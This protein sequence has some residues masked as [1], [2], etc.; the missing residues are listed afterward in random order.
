MNLYIDCIGGVAGDMLLAALIDAGAPLTTINAELDKLGIPGLMA[1]VERV[2]RHSLD[3]CHVNVTWNNP[4]SNDCNQHDDRAGNSPHDDHAHDGHASDGHC[5]H[6]DDAHDGPNDRHG[7]RQYAEIRNMLH[8][9][10]LATRVRDR[11]LCAF[12]LLAAAESRMHGIESNDVHFHEV[13]SEDSIADVVGVSVAL[14]L[15]EVDDVVC[16]PLPLGRGFVKSAHGMLPLPAPA[17][18]EIL[19]GIPTEGVD[20]QME[21]VTPTGAALVASLSSS[22]GTFPSMRTAAVGY[23]A[24]RRDLAQRPNIVRVVLGKFSEDASNT[25]LRPISNEVVLLETN[26]DDCSPELV[27]DAVAAAMTA[28][29]LD[30]WTTPAF[31]KKGRPG[32]VLSALARRGDVAGVADAML[33]ETSALGIRMC[34]YQRIEL[35]RS[36]VVVLVDNEPVSVKLG[37][38]DNEVVNVAP[39]HDD[40]A[41]VAAKLSKPVKEVYARALTAALAAQPK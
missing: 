14:E 10:G 37:H 25:P 11:A 15:L 32:F 23:G 27:P 34:A 12:D 5:H 31:M 39:E 8:S 3:C 33:S 40:C 6:D 35:E 20:I 17:T 2:T 19:K 16:S 28:G 24:G 7:Q 9:A 26:L 21:L 4:T 38:R 18:L 36:F 22:F 30:V 1:N 13:G 41:R 29:A